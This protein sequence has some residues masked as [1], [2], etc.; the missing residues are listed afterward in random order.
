MGWGSI[1]RSS[2][3]STSFDNTESPASID[4]SRSDSEPPPQLPTTTAVS[5]THEE[6]KRIF[7][8][9]STTGDHRV[10]AQS[11]DLS[12]QGEHL[13]RFVDAVLGDFKIQERQKKIVEQEDQFT[14]ALSRLSSS[15]PQ[16]HSDV[17]ATSQEDRGSIEAKVNILGASLEVLHKEQKIALTKIESILTSTSFVYAVV[18]EKCASMGMDQAAQRFFEKAQKNTI[19]LESLWY[20]LRSMEHLPFHE[21]RNKRS[22]LEEIRQEIP[23]LM[24]VADIEGVMPLPRMEETIPSDREAGYMVEA[25]SLGLLHDALLAEKVPEWATLTSL[26]A[27]AEQ[28][29]TSRIGLASAAEARLH[30]LNGLRSIVLATMKGG[31]IEQ[32][33]EEQGSQEAQRIFEEQRAKLNALEQMLW[34]GKL[35]ESDPSL[36]EVFAL[37]KWMLIWDGNIRREHPREALQGIALEL[38][39]HEQN[40]LVIQKKL[41]ELRR[42]APHLFSPHGT[43]NPDVDVSMTELGKLAAS[44]ARSAYWISRSEMREQGL[45]LLTSVGGAIGGFFLGGLLGAILGGGLGGGLG[46]GSNAIYNVHQEDASAAY[47]E[48]LGTGITRVGPDDAHLHRTALGWSV[49]MST[50]FGAMNGMPVAVGVQIAREGASIA[51]ASI[52]AHGSLRAALRSG[53]GAM[54]RGTLLLSQKMVE[55]E[56][57]RGIFPAAKRFVTGGIQNIPGGIRGSA[58][59]LG[60]ASALLGSDMTI[61]G[62]AGELDTLPGAVGAAI[63]VNEGASF[64]MRINANGLLVGNLFRQ[65]TE[66]AMQYQQDMPLTDPDPK[67]MA[68]ASVES[69]TMVFFVKT[70]VRGNQF[71]EKFPIGRVIKGGYEKTMEEAPWLKP[72]FVSITGRG[73]HTFHRLN[74]IVMKQGRQYSNGVKWNKRG[75]IELPSGMKFSRS[76]AELHADELLK[77]QISVEPTTGELVYWE[78][79]MLASLRVGGRLVSSRHPLSNGD[80]AKLEADGIHLLPEGGFARQDFAGIRLGKNGGLDYEVLTQPVP[81]SY[82]MIGGKDLPIWTGTSPARPSFT[83]IGGMM[84]A[85]LTG[86]TAWV[87]NRVLFSKQMRGDSEYQPMQRLSNYIFSELVTHP[88]VQWPLGYDTP[89]AQLA[90]RTIGIGVNLGANKLFPTYRQQ[91]PG[92]VTY[93]QAL[94]GDKSDDAFENF[95]DNMT[96][97]EVVPLAFED[98]SND[99][100]LWEAPAL[101]TFREQHDAFMKESLDPGRI[102]KFADMMQSK[103]DAERRGDLPTVDRRALRLLAAYVHTL[104]IS[105]PEERL[106]AFRPLRD[107]MKTTPSLF[108][109]LPPLRSEQEWEEFIRDVNHDRDPARDF[110]FHVAQE[111]SMP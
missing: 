111:K 70:Y 75:D 91:W 90:G 1:P 77:H 60:A 36:K 7:N 65:G 44:R 81:M 10:I 103:I 88:Y 107:V 18:A 43:L 14:K 101:R 34:S 54:G 19:G 108:E 15:C 106:E 22:R 16:H 85:S 83:V 82:A 99:W 86:G 25:L 39:P 46:A 80:K 72:V 27:E 4:F 11:V 87:L 92:Q 79:E 61:F 24:A 76:E 9:V 53:L 31:R 52:L 47:A 102:R 93:F 55:V 95:T 13:E 5:F 94:D 105:D 78:P 104:L 71:L 21:L 6:W 23:S 30:V 32:A 12:V 68:W 96:S 26:E 98:T 57:W 64:L 49:G 73:R 17:E 69:A 38:A 74:R 37:A 41:S 100:W 89:L 84:T 110:H 40:S 58:I 33:R 42:E 51:G 35:R 59:R 97:F 20:E 28:L 8:T 29:V 63:F 62:E 56:T 50:A 48:S 3:F 45:P 2:A 66:W 109:G 67:R